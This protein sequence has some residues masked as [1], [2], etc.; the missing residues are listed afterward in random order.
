MRAAA[1]ATAAMSTSTSEAGH[2]VH[3]GG[4]NHRSL[5][6]SVP[7]GPPSSDGSIPVAIPVASYHPSHPPQPQPQQQQ[8]HQQQ[9]G[10]WGGIGSWFS[11]S[12]PSQPTP[13]PPS[14]YY[15]NDE[16][17]QQYV[18]SGPMLI[19]PV[20]G[21]FT[22]Q[23]PGAQTFTPFQM[24]GISCCPCCVP[25]CCIP[26]RKQAW[27]RFCLSANFIL[28]VIQT[29]L[30]IVSIALHGFSSQNSMLGPS[31][32]MLNTFQGKNSAEIVYNKQ[33]WRLVTPIFLH[34]GLLHLAMN[35]AIQL[36]LGVLLE[37]QWGMVPYLF[38]Y[39]GSGVVGSVYSAIFNADA[40]GVGASGALLGVFGA[41][42]SHMA[43]HWSQGDDYTRRQRKFNLWMAL[44]NVL[45]I[46]AFSFSPL[47]DWAAHLG[48]LGG[49][50]L[51]GLWY[52]GR[53]LDGQVDFDFP[54]QPS[55]SS[56]SSQ[57]ASLAAPLSPGGGPRRFNYV[58]TAGGGSRGLF[59]CFGRSGGRTTGGASS[60]SSSPPSCCSK[61]FASTFNC[62]KDAVVPCTKG[63][64]TVWAG[65]FGYFVVLVAGL[66]GL[67]FNSNPSRALLTIPP[68]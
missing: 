25:P 35:M 18:G 29:I 41:W 16:P 65:L 48:G 9:R 38:I 20:W 2:D 51:L 45:I 63:K 24:L 26:A 57:M 55:Q 61:H 28:A 33:L 62:S 34:A 15:A 66:L 47:I 50:M 37:Y 5:P 31:P 64:A 6:L 8:Q 10:R 11:S 60:S 52:F 1:E 53:A 14:R 3:V 43:L 49:G 27:R 30:V 42:I 44:F 21:A 22:P 56:Q 59:G 36:R 58:G 67:F 32:A 54:N 19:D 7:G 68:Y 4:N 17:Q 12:S 46:I 39:F 23:P 13:P 40:I